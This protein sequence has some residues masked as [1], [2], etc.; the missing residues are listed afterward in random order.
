MLDSSDSVAPSA[1]APLMLLKLIKS[2]LEH[3]RTSKLVSRLMIWVALIQCSRW[4]L[5]Y[6]PRFDYGLHLLAYS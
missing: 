3:T 5:E 1:S 6:H 2:G 4:V